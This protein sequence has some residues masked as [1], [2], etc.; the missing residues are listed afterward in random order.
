MLK[1]LNPC[2]GVKKKMGI[3]IFSRVRDW[4]HLCSKQL[5]YTGCNGLSIVLG[6]AQSGGGKGEHCRSLYDPGMHPDLF[7]LPIRISLFSRSGF[8]L[9]T[10]WHIR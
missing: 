4:G 5:I 10:H 7:G 8:S 3:Q 9:L 6:V 1:A 2:P